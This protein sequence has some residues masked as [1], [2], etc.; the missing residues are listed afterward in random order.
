MGVSAPEIP[1]WTVG[2]ALKPIGWVMAGTFIA[3]LGL[4][5][6]WWT[7]VFVSEVQLGTDQLHS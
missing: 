6:T 4:V 1:A 5:T 3:S 2:K 7:V